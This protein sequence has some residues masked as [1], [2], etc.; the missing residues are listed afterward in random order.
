MLEAGWSTTTVEQ[1]HVKAS[2]WVQKQPAYQEDSM[3]ARAMVGSLSPL[4]SDVAETTKLVVL[5]QR[6]ERLD[7]YQAQYFV[8]RQLFLRKVQE[9]SV[10]LE[11]RCRQIPKD[12]TKRLLL[13]K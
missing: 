13:K 2:R 10:V 11:A 4:L 9:V 5:E 3:R 8:G 6:A 1:A 12:L 7:Q